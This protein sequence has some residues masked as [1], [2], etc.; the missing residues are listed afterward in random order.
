MAAFLIFYKFEEKKILWNCFNRQEGFAK[1][2]TTWKTAKVT[3]INCIYKAGL[4]KL[5]TDFNSSKVVEGYICSI[6]NDH[7]ET[8]N[9]ISPHQCGFLQ[10]HLTEDIL[11]Q[12]IERWFGALIWQSVTSHSHEKTCSLWRYILE[13]FNV[14]WK[15]T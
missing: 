1:S 8:F 4:L 2:V 14:T 15:A 12:M 5:Q 11:L 3:Y 7:P 10:I 9:L 13:I 6:L